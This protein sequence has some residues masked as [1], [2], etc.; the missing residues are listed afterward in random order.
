LAADSRVRC[1]ILLQKG[2]WCEGRVIR[3]ENAG[4]VILAPGLQ[5]GADV[6]VL[7]SVEGR[8]YTFEA[9]V[10]R[11]GIPV[12][13]RSQH[14]VVLGF[15]QGW[16]R[17]DEGGRGLVLELLP[18]IG[19]VVSLM[20]G[21]VQLI[22]LQPALWTVAASAGSWFV[23]AEQGQVRLRMGL[24]G[25]SPVELVARV[26]SVSRSDAHLLYAL[27]IEQVGSPDR[28]REVLAGFQSTLK[29]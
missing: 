14:G 27:K 16:R 1:D 13:D 4:L 17:A 5:S 10:I 6:R 21:E 24:P 19:G 11:T 8:S 3:A 7:L 12:P 22:E 23:L 20:G 26:Q 25:Q 29:L 15:I 28:Y 9:S 2:G 18:A